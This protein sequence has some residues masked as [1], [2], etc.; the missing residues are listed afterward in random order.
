MSKTN[1]YTI[2]GL[3]TL[4]TVLERTPERVLSVAIAQGKHDERVDATASPC[5]GSV[6]SNW[7]NSWVR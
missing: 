7:P 4:Q 3:H 6:T 1:H 2:Y 5:N